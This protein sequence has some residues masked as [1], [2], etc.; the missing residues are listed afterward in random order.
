MD[1]DYCSGGTDE[2]HRKSA[3]INDYFLTTKN[4]KKLR[5][6]Y[7]TTYFLT[8]KNTKGHEILSMVVL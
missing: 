4:T 7:S 1:G 2:V 5:V 8:T 3:P 6:D